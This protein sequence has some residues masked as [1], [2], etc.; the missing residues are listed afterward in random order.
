LGLLIWGAGAVLTMRREL[1]RLHA[2]TF[3]G[4]TGTFP[5]FRR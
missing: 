4:P 1:H 5:D 3:I 2:V